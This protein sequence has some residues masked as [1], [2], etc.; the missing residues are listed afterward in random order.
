LNRQL[1][2]KWHDMVQRS[3]QCARELSSGSA[4]QRLARLFLLL[5]PPSVEHC[6]LFGREDVGAL[7]AI[8]TETASRV[9]SD[10]KRRKVVTE[11]TSN[12]FRRDI[13]VLQ[14]IADGEPSG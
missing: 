4:R 9:V 1:I 12:V 14:T 8:T 11:I 2:G 13:A 6:R 10:F 5:A 7:L 3:H